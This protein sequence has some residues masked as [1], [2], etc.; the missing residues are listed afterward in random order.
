MQLNREL[1][2]ATLD[3]QKQALAICQPCIRDPDDDSNGS[4]TAMAAGLLRNVAVTSF[5]LEPNA[6]KFRELLAESAELRLSLFD[7]YSAGEPI[8][9]SFLTIISYQ[10]V[11]DA[12]A[13]HRSDIAKSFAPH[14]T[15]RETL[16]RKHCH[17]FDR[18]IGYAILAA[19]SDSQNATDLSADFIDYCGSNGNGSFVGYATFLDGIINRDSQA[20]EAGTQGIIKA[21]KR[22]SGNG[23]FR[24]TPDE[25]LCVWGIGLCFLARLKGLTV[26]LDHPLIPAVLLVSGSQ[27]E[28]MG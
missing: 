25:L 5:S 7:R 24:G 28:A 17:K 4:A 10:A 9:D 18:T 13:A 11:L 22:L 16:N 27:A 1:L 14:L 6:L 21:H 2:L 20:V 8:D 12:L 26:D 23:I 15:G 19:I 3:A